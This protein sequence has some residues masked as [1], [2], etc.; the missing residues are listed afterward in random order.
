MRLFPI[1]TGFARICPDLP[2]FAWKLFGNCLNV[3]SELDHRVIHV[4]A[5][6]AFRMCDAF[7]SQSGRS[8]VSCFWQP[9]RPCA[10]VTCIAA[11]QANCMC[12]FSR[13]QFGQTHV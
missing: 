3:W 4:A 11:S 10:W 13:T 9:V 1:A 6:Q 2:G 12:D 8:H 5:S 7:R